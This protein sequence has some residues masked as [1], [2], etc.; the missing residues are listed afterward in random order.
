MERSELLARLA[1]APERVA[2]AAR[3][4]AEADERAG[5]PPTGEW[6]AREVVG[7]LVNVES[8]VWHARLDS[9]DAGGTPSWSWTE[10]GPAGDP[11]TGTL[12][13]ALARFTTLRAETVA[14]VAG[15]DDA[16]WARAGIHAAYGRLDMAGLLLVAVEHDDEH[17][18]GLEARGGG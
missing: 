10:P 15:L 8:L 14:R 5:G 12:E 4:T 17:H 9:L 6:S 16:G 2:T 7:H 3:R 13:G 11:A 1:A 18:D